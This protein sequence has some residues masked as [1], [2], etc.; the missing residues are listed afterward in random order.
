MNYE[1]ES[2]FTRAMLTG[3]F[4]GVIDTLICL[5]YN[6]GYR[7]ATGYAPSGLINVSSLIFAVNL[8]LLLIGMLYYI[9]IKI[10]G[11]RDIVFATVFAS[12]TAVGCWQT[13]IGHRF[14]D[15]S[16]NSGFKGLLVGIVLI[17]GVSATALPALYH[18]KFFDKY[19]L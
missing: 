16:V 12:I 11:K 13:E 18:S 9:F 4:I 8:I 5:S 10:F 6:I 14:V 3:L 7:D 1:Q 19:V 15:P 17:L 2:I